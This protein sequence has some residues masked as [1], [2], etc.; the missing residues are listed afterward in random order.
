MRCLVTGGAGFIGSHIVDHLISAGHT[1]AVIDNLST[2]Q[3][4]FVNTKAILY[5][6]DIRDNLNI[7]FK[8]EKPE[9]IIHTAAQVMLRESL[10]DPLNDASINVIGTLNL[11]ETC[12][13]HDVKKLIYT[14]TIGRIGEPEYLPVDEKHPVNPTSPYGISK[15]VAEK[16][17]Q[18]YSKLYGIDYRIFCFGNVYG[19]RDNPRSK[20]VTGLFAHSMIHEKQPTIFGDGNQTRDFIFVEDL[21][22]F[23]VET[24][25]KKNKH[26]LFNLANGKQIKVNEIFKILAELIN[27][28]GKPKYIDAIKG[29]IRD[30]KL[31]TTLAQKE[32]GWQPK[33]TF[34]DGLRK[35]VE[36]FKRQL[37]SQ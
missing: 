33:H 30:I 3:K 11:L 7:V 6:K 36:W 15:Y 25:N 1:V 18:M 34:E 14:S 26:N 10:K 4:K 23:I 9:V 8:K 13:K 16:Y 29:E 27:Y 31:D 19:P 12:R 17:V 2:G 5:K 32:L 28:Q 37:T 21:A 22:E 20:R 35:T 24:M